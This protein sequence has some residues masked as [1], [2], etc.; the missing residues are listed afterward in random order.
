MRAKPR[1]TQS[2]RERQAAWKRPE[3]SFHEEPCEEC[4]RRE[5]K[6]R[7]DACLARLPFE[8]REVF[9]LCELEEKDYSEAARQLSIPVGT[10]RSRLHRA[11]LALQRQFPL[12]EPVLGGAR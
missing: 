10:V 12:P 8:Q 6:D 2:C 7:L 11:R 1:P 4:Q 5:L 9:R 3:C